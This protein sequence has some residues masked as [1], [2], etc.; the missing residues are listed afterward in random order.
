MIKTLLI[1]GFGPFPGIRSNPSAALVKRL[2]RDLTL[3]RNG[4]AVVPRLIPTI[5][6]AADAML[7]EL[8]GLKPDAVLM[9]GVAAKRKGLS[10]EIQARNRLAQH[11][12]A[13]GKRGPRPI[14]AAHAPARIAG[15]APF[16]RIVQSGRGCGIRVALSRNAGTYLC[17]YAYWQMLD[18]LPRDT[19]C[20][21]VHVPKL[22]GRGLVK[23]T[24]A[25]VAIGQLL[26]DRR[27]SEFKP[28][29]S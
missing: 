25:L 23:A 4:I 5:Y 6:A 18:A 8:I 22:G 12:D 9:L 11:P 16:A 21:F 10:V 29:A 3:K 17:N 19:P 14:I 20:V 28:A 15:R 27:R 13:A 26:S 7:P 24:R 1:T 2:A